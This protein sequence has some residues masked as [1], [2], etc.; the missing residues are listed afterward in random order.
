MLAASLLPL[1]LPPA[2]LLAPHLPPRS[3]PGTRTEVSPEMPREAQTEHECQLSPGGLRFLGRWRWFVRDADG[4][5]GCFGWRGCFLAKEES[6]RARLN[7]VHALTWLA[8]GPA[9]SM[10]DVWPL[11]AGHQRVL[12]RR[13]LEPSLAAA[14]SLQQMGLIQLGTAW[15]FPCLPRSP[16]AR[17]R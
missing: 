1:Q 4:A 17:L 5:G 14:E 13:R 9:P 11:L 15:C 3:G 8:S 6:P 12:G 10:L 2:L 7:Q 16:V